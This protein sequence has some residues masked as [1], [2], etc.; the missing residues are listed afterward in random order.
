LLAVCRGK[1]SEGINLSDA[2]SR[3]IIIIGLPYPSVIDPRIR[4][5]QKH[6]DYMRTKGRM[7]LL[8]GNTW[9]QQHTLRAINQA[10]GRVIRHRKDY[11]TVILMDARFAKYDVLSQ[12]SHW[13]RSSNKCLERT[14]DRINQDLVDF[15]AY[16][17]SQ[18]EILREKQ[19]QIEQDAKCNEP[20]ELPI[21][22]IF[23]F[24][25]KST[26]ITPDIK[27]EPTI[28]LPPFRPSLRRKA[29]SGPRS[30][31]EPKR[32]AR[33]YRKPKVEICLDEEE[34]VA[35]T[36]PTQ[37]PSLPQLSSTHAIHFISDD[38]DDDKFETIVL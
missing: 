7:Q 1:V 19:I 37:S 4:M 34:D 27:E 28:I 3:C 26:K 33:N 29:S 35:N 14:M 6:N 8:P 17:R 32:P 13:L 31:P 30:S 25:G 11:G 12:L 24:F 23:S 36:V 10:A 18:A 15:F 21:R 16:H 5:K 22:P 2:A 9:L 38:D 20:E